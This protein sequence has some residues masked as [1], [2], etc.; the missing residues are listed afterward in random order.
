MSGN[1]EGV[2]GVDFTRKDTAPQFTL[3]LRLKDLSGGEWMY[4]KANTAL[5]AYLAYK[6]LPVGT[7]GSATAKDDAIDDNAASFTGGCFVCWPQ[8]AFSASDYGWVRISGSFT[9]KIVTGISA[10]DK[11]YTST[12]AGVLGGTASAHFHLFGDVLAVEANS[13]GSD[14][15]KTIKCDFPV[16]LSHIAHP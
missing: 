12:T 6:I 10:G 2:G 9:G 3:G 5:T 1:I 7:V 8:Q 11:L 13:S 16:H 14:A 4:V 15:N